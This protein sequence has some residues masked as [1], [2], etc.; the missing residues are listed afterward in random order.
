MRNLDKIREKI[1][2]VLPNYYLIRF[3]GILN[4]FQISN[5]PQVVYVH[6]NPILN[7]LF[8]NN[9]AER[10][11]FF[12]INRC[13]YFIRDIIERRRGS[14]LDTLKIMLESENGEKVEMTWDGK[15]IIVRSIIKP[16][17]NGARLEV[18]LIKSIA[19]PFTLAE[20]LFLSGR[21]EIFGNYIPLEIGRFSPTDVESI[22]EFLESW[23]HEK[24][25]E[26]ILSPFFIKTTNANTI[27]EGIAEEIDKD[28]LV[29]RLANHILMTVKA[30]NKLFSNE[31]GDITEF[32]NNKE[33]ITE[34]A[35][36]FW[37]N[38]PLL[39]SDPICPKKEIFKE[40][41]WTIHQAIMKGEIRNTIEEVAHKIS[42]LVD[43]STL[44]LRIKN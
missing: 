37:I 17:L 4:V 43:F 21:K 35:S 3:D 41:A 2:R 1:K 24:V 11:I 22:R 34:I 25:L 18:E 38:K 23:G 12:L 19:R 44:I 29:K 26:K 31:L 15:S 13:K 27:I 32:K 42:E 10:E 8:S 16:T 14:F 5:D 9:P 40:I 30:I 20:I 7:M 36:F 39:R 28:I 6:E 33:L